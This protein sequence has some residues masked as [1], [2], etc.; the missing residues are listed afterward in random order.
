MERGIE[1]EKEKQRKRGTDGEIKKVKV[2][3]KQIILI[4]Q[5]KE[6]IEREY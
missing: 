5:F 3:K 6:K 4:K 2:K 1:T